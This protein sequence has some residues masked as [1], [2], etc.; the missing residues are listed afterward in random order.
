[1]K[2]YLM[3]LDV[4]FILLYIGM[5]LLLNYL[6]RLPR[7]IS[8]FDLILIGLASARLTDIISTDEVMAWLR[9]PFIQLEETE[10]AGREVEIRE[11]KGDGFRKVIGDLLSCPWCIGVWIAAGLSYAY[12][13]FPRVVW[14][15]VL[16]MA[17]AE[18]SSILQTLTTIF[19]RLEK[20]FKGLGVPDEGI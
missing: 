20:Y 14:L 18:I 6:G 16:I 11:G 1:M 5:M 3:L 13:L 12:F 2:R 17:I 15:F 19:V 8:V 10:I 4:I 7:S 9:E